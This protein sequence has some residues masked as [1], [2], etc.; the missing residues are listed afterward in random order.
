MRQLINVSK[1]KSFKNLVEI[2]LIGNTKTK[3]KESQEFRRQ[4]ATNHGFL[5]HGKQKE[6]GKV[7]LVSIIFNVW[8]QLLLYLIEWFQEIGLGQKFSQAQ[9]MG[10]K[11]DWITLLCCSVV[12]R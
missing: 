8:S 4:N 6:E 1:T 12:I 7:T 3:D 2:S 11:L 5:V 10:L 9:W